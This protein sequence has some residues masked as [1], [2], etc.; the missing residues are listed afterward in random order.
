[1]PYKEHCTRKSGV[2]S[3]IKIPLRLNPKGIK[4]SRDIAETSDEKHT[5]R[6]C[7]NKKYKKWPEKQKKYLQ[8]YAVG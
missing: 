8:G 3:S 2:F 7:N 6:E 5:K 1:L 4:Y